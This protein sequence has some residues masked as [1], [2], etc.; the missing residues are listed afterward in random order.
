MASQ[1]SDEM[2][3]IGGRWWSFPGAQIDLYSS[4]FEW[5]DG[6]LWLHDGV[7]NVVEGV[8]VDN[9]ELGALAER[10]GLRETDVF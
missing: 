2:I 1:N 7:G 10:H 4:E 3:S 8:E 9:P 6:K 5:R